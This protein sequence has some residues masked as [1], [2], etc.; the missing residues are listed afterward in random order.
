MDHLSPAPADANAWNAIA[1]PLVDPDKEVFGDE[2]KALV[3][4]R[5]AVD[6]SVDAA[7]YQVRDTLAWALFKLGRFDEALA[8][9]QKALDEA[10]EKE[11]KNYEALVKKLES[12]IKSW[13]SPSGEML[14]AREKEW[15]ELSADVQEI[16]KL[17]SARQDWTFEDSEDR[18]WHVQLTKLIANLEAF[19]DPKSGLFSSGIS[20]EHGWGIEKRAAFARTIEEHSVSG[21]D[22]AQRWAEAIASI[23]DVKQCPK[24]EGLVL[25]PQL[26]LLPI[27]RDK[28]SGLWEFAHVQ[29]GDPAERGDDGKLLLKESI[30]IVLVLIPGG[31]FKMG[32]QSTDASEPNYDPQARADE[33]RVHEVTLAPYFMS[34]YEMTQGQW[35]RFVGSNPSQYGPHNY[36]PDWND[37]H[38]ARGSAAPGGASE[39][40]RL[41]GDTGAPRPRLADRSAMGASCARGDRHT[42]VDW[43]RNPELGRRRER[44]GQVREAPRRRGMDE[45]E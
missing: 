25:T 41:H 44:G 6:G 7:R 45:L 1:W 29:S 31:T 22:A 27:G 26:G 23:R 21:P 35:L 12:A 40:A 18:W 19:A 24:Y 32:A 8:Q 37:K 2:V 38:Q 5:R 10:P 3:C 39:L 33:S 16:E 9:E 4:A 36:S 14:P 30:G 17:V 13:R 28:D 34:K 20:K 15:S 43:D 42:V 11:K